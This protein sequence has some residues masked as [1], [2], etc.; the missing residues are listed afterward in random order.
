MTKEPEI[1]VSDFNRKITIKRAVA[2]VDN[3]AGSSTISET[4]IYDNI[5]ADVDGLSTSRKQ[6]LGIEAFRSAFDMIF[7]QGVDLTVADLIYYE[8]K[9]YTIHSVQLVTQWYKRFY[10]IVAVD[11]STTG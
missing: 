4:T 2:V 3:A 7:R 5:W 1:L 10:I 11:V 6:Y 9:I 8:N